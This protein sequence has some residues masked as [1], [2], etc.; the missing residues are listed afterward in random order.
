MAYAFWEPAMKDFLVLKNKLL[1]MWI[2]TK[3]ILKMQKSEV[4]MNAAL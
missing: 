3:S 4:E 2:E 1:S